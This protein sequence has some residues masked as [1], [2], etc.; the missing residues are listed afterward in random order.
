MRRHL[1]L[2]LLLAPLALTACREEIV[3]LPDPVPLT[4]TA[5]SYYCQMWIADHGG[6]KAQIH[7]EG[8]PGPIF[9]A[10]V[11]DAVAYLR[12]PE[13]DAP[14]IA[15]YVSDMEKAKSW[16]E[17]GPTNWVAAK[18][19][20]FVVG[21]D[22]KGGMGAPEIAPFGTLAAAKRFAED[23]G[24]NVMSL[25]EIP[26]EVVLAPVDLDLPGESH[27]TVENPEPRETTQ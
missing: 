14:V 26:S 23:R 7:L 8:M 25:E 27:Q 9:F 3:E 13:R 2:S 17:P 21:A 4:E 19:A 6:P 15:V 22:V 11:R 20:S 18:A 5:L 16:D 10:Q 1:L 12:S 24:G